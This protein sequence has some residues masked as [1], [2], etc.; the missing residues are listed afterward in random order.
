M[1]YARNADIDVI[2]TDA[3][4]RALPTLAALR[5]GSSQVIVA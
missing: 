1:T 4:A 3:G 5:K 2:V